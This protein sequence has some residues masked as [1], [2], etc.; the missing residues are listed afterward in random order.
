M[1]QMTKHDEGVTIATLT[2][3][4][5]SIF[6]RLLYLFLRGLDIYLRDRIFAADKAIL[7]FTPFGFLMVD[8]AACG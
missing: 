5:T 6:R 7:I 2:A 1:D 3:F 8:V 4:H